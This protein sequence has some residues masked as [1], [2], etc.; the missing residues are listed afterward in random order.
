MME[1]PPSGNAIHPASSGVKGRRTLVEAELIYSVAWL[2]RLRWI[3]GIGVLFV[4]WVVTALFKFRVPIGILITIGAGILLYNTLFYSLEKKLTRLTASAPKYQKLAIWQVGLDWLAMILLIHFTGGVESPV[5]F[6]FLFHIIIA[7]ILFPQRTAFAFVISAIGLI[8]ITTLLEYHTVL[9]HV[10]IA[11]FLDAALYQNSRYIL[12]FLIFFGFTG[13][14]AAYLATT[15]S[16]RLRQREEEVVELTESL[17]RA[18]TR[19]Q[20]LNQGARTITSSLNL[21]HVLNLLAKSVAEVLQVRACSIRL[22]DESGKRLQ[23]VASYGLSQAYLDKGPIDLETNPLAREVVSGKI[24][25]VPDVTKS[26]I[27]QYPEWAKS[28]GISSMLSAPL[29]GKNGPLGILR[30]YSNE[31]DHFT[32][33]DE[34]FLEAIAAQGSVAIDNALAYKAIEELD[35]TKSTFIRMVTHELRSPVSVT[36]SLLRTITAGYTGDVNEQQRDILERATRRIDF[37]QK[38]IDDL[39]ELA[40]GKVEIKISDEI[41]PIILDEVLQR[42]IK[43]YE[44][45]AKEK[46]IDLKFQSQLREGSTIVMATSE[47]LD[48][49]FNNLI[50]NAVKYTLPGGSVLVNLQHMG[51]EAWITVKDTGIGIPEDALGHLFEEFFRASNAKELVREGTGLGLTI[52]KDSVTRFGGR[53]SVQSKLRE[54]T[55]LTVMLPL[56]GKAQP[57][58]EAELPQPMSK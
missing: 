35:A 55:L 57:V 33:D 37:L 17:Q 54:G 44:V 23:L 19:L 47:G 52:V 31:R 30:V 29:I 1:M 3:A 48:R 15:I 20:V 53:V 43:R 25:H 5:I 18:T 4:T 49:I 40:A 13:F 42:V 58:I 2:I 46:D 28:E 34:I 6:F 41:A 22:L 51:K 27:L 39:L 45:S 21:S 32:S 8:T 9:P 14:I 36:R 50:S 56:K 10:P 38:L 26:S 16:E 24:V 7:S 11:G 12:A